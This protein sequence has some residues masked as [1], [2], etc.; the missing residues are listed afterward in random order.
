MISITLNFITEFPKHNSNHVT[1]YTSGYF[2][3]NRTDLN[4]EDKLL[5]VY[6]MASSGL[7]KMLDLIILYTHKSVSENVC[8]V[9]LFWT[10]KKTNKTIDVPCVGMWYA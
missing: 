2:I 5:S 3:Q 10:Q 9:I 8:P 7:K 6:N 1:L 4:L